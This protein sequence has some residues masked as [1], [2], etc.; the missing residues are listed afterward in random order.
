MVQGSVRATNVT[1]WRDFNFDTLFHPY[2][3]WFSGRENGKRWSTFDTVSKVPTTCSL[4]PSLNIHHSADRHTHTRTRFVCNA[5]FLSCCVSVCFFVRLINY[6][7][8]SPKETRLWRWRVPSAKR[9][10]VGNSGAKL[11]QNLGFQRNIWNLLCKLQFLPFHKI[12]QNEHK[13]Q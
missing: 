13:I 11:G 2:F 5:Y 8:F 12:V 4:S 6:S 1:G 7:N 10:T 9:R 3:S